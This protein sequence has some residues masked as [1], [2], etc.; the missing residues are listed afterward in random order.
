MIDPADVGETGRG[1]GASLS[2]ADR[3]MTA[4]T[5]PAQGQVRTS[6]VVDRLNTTHVLILTETLAEDAYLD[7]AGSPQ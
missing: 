7:W 1:S 6:R 4:C 2:D 5:T 3:G